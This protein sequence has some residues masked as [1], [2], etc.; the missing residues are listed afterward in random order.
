MTSQGYIHI[1]LYIY[2][3]QKHIIESILRGLTAILR[4]FMGYVCL[5]TF[6]GCVEGL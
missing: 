4:R 1:D 2:H 6:K 5:V 3:R